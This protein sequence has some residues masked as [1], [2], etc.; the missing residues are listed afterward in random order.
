MIRQHAPRKRLACVR[1]KYSQQ[2]TRKIINALW[3]VADVM[4]MLETRRRDEKTQMPE[5]SWAGAA[6]NATDGRASY[7]R[8]AIPRVASHRVVA[9]DSAGRTWIET[10]LSRL[11]AELQTLRRSGVR[12]R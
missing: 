10:R 2:I 3:A 4:T 12:I 1:R 6:A 9:R 11:K 7:A 8:L 5:K